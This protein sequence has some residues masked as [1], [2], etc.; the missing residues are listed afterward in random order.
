MAT[1]EPQQLQD[2]AQLVGDQQ[3]GTTGVFEQES[4]QVGK[5]NYI[6]TGTTTV[7]KSGQG[8]LLQIIIGKTTTGTVTVYDNTAASGN[9][10]CAFGT[11][12]T[13][14]AFTIGAIANTGITVV[15]SAADQVSVIYV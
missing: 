2:N 7:V 15:T 9:I 13:P 1:S 11:S 8:A 12:T 10:I 14:F 3:I 4:I 6:S 5:Y